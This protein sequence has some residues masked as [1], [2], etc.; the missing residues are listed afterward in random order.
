MVNSLVC[1]ELNRNKCSNQDFAC[2]PTLNPLKGWFWMWKKANGPDDYWYSIGR[3]H[4][5]YIMEVNSWITFANLAIFIMFIWYSNKK[6]IRCMMIWPFY[7]WS[8]CEDRKSNWLN[9]FLS[10]VHLM[11][12]YKMSNFP[13]GHERPYFN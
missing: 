8:H 12:C 7:Y 9:I 11:F 2:K 13:V 4:F 5:A 10:F 3:S 6:H 1:C